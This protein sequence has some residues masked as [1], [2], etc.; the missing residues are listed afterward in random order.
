MNKNSRAGSPFFHLLRYYNHLLNRYKYPVQ[1]VTGGILWLS[2]DL[3]CQTIVYKSSQD[4][5]NINFEIDW[6]RTLKMTTYGLLFSAPIYGFWYSFLDKW[7]HRVFTSRGPK[8]LNPSPSSSATFT[9]NKWLINLLGTTKLRTWK[10]IG[11]KL[12]ADTFI[13]DPIYLS[14]FFTST[15]LMEGRSTMEITKKLKEDLLHTYLVDIAVWTPIQTIN[16]RWIPVIYQPIV[17]QFCNIGWNAYLS[18]VQHY[19]IVNHSIFNSNSNFN[20]NSSLAFIND[21]NSCK[22]N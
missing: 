4:K 1:I 15:S 16:F 8:S 5:R 6:N 14:I 12:L 9:I 2:G 11:F 21:K 3:L 17:V 10:I 7:S 22:K 13:F 20:S 18:F 19:D